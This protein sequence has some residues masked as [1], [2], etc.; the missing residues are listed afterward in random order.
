VKGHRVGWFGIAASLVAAFMLA[1]GSSEK[2]AKLLPVSLPDLSRVDP[3]VQAQVRERYETLTQKLARR[4][5]PPEELGDAYGALGM[6][7]QAAEYFDAAETA[8]LDAQMLAPAEMK[9]PY[10]LARTYKGKGETD[11]AEAS[12]RRVLELRPDDLATLIWLGRLYLDQGRADAAESLFSKAVNEAPRTVAALAGLGRVA[13]A[14]R[15]YAAAATHFDAA[16]AID[17][18]ADSLHAQLAAAYRGLGDV[19]K[20]EQQLRHWRNT[21]IF[22]PDPLG[23]ELDLLLE[24]GLSY[25]LRGVRAFDARDW[26][27]AEAFFRHGLTLARDNTPLARSLH[28]KLGTALVLKGDVSGAMRQFEEVTRLA[29]PAG[30][31][32]SAA[33]AHYSLGIVL[34]EQGRHADALRHLD[35]AVKY[36]PTYVEAHLA[37]AD[38]LR[39]DPQRG[40]RVGDAARR[41]RLEASLAHY[42]EA[43]QINPRSTPARLGYALA[44]AALGR[45]QQARDSLTESTSLYPDR[46]EFAIALARLF[47]ASPDDRVRDGR[48]ALALAGKLF[49]QQK[50]TDVGEAL[51]MALAELG[52]YDRAAGIQRGI[53][54]APGN[55]GFAVQRMK[56]NLALYQSGRPC[57]TP[58]PVDQPVVLSESPALPPAI[59][60][61]H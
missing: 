19:D 42:G 52:D 11:K 7:L 40:G 36:Q 32:E 22:V 16:L 6:V 35:A 50:S 13:L 48:A 23:Q 31:D 56:V 54:A 30:I 37:L 59:A 25:E 21:D 46:Q 2:R 49:E 57:R 55:A 27:S 53:I 12:Y 14:K 4:D 58:W 26:E 1:C 45:W 9:W 34:E 39:R 15:E 33:K 41:A 3:G 61:Q 8:Y 24:S 44:L 10:Y 51:A 47:A 18:E 29:P 38:A 20:A 17:P 28:H 43:I 60:A 5:T